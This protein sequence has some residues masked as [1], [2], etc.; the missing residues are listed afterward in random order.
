MT[1]VIARPQNTMSEGQF[2]ISI[3]C[4][5]VDLMARKLKEA[6]RSCMWKTARYVVRFF[7]DL[8]NCHVISTNSLMKLYQSFLD[9]AREDNAPQGNKCHDIASLFGSYTV[10]NEALALS[11]LNYLLM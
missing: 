3:L 1:Q 6:L 4:Q 2:N 10:N 7:A 5:F 11:C 8:V 9:T